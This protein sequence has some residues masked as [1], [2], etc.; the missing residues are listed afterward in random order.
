MTISIL[1]TAEDILPG[2]SHDLV[3]IAINMWLLSAPSVCSLFFPLLFS[4]TSVCYT[5]P[6]RLQVRGNLEWSIPP[7][8][9]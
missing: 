3:S 5:F 9:V 2:P 1:P 8:P 6:S 4:S 7:S